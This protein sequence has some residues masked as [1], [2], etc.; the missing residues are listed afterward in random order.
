MLKNRDF[1]VFGLQ[2]WSIDIG[3]TCKYTAQEIAKNNR[4]LYVSVPINRKS[5]LTNKNSKIVQDYN[6][7]L[8]GSQPALTKVGENIWN[9]NPKTI[10]ESINWIGNPSV[11]DFFNKMNDKRIY[12]EIQ[13]A[14]NELGFKD[15]ILL[16]DNSMIIGQYFKEFFKPKAYVYLLRDAVTMVS[17]HAKHGKRLEPELIKKVDFVV[18]N[19]EFFRN[20]ASEFNQ[21]SY[22]I[23]QGCNLELYNDKSGNLPIPDEMKVYR[24]PIIGY[25]GFLTTIRL[26]IELLIKI[27]IHN[28]KWSLVLVGPEDEDFKKSKLHD[29]EN[30]YFLGKRPINDLPAYIKSFDVA[31]NPQIVNP[32]TDINYPLKIDEYLAMGKPTVATKTSFMSYF[33]NYVYLCRDAEEWILNILKAL[34][35]NT[36]EREKE[37]IAYAST[38]SWGHFV[39]KIYNQLEKIL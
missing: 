28:K 15:V 36:P 7:I 27:A 18:T 14:I 33:G 16:N 30:V 21:K 9:L 34:E 22:L 4:V 11:F 12:K 3:S 29:L 2:S 6:L 39:E 13:K 32:I 1:I 24:K 5:L 25:V 19:S 37:R 31:I 23:G 35:E 10:I 20:Y 17:Y 8:N 38:H 26:D